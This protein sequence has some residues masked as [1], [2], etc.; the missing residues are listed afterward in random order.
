L[1][2]AILL[3]SGGIDSATLL[4]KVREEYEVHA[5]TIRYGR[6]NRMEVKSSRA[7]ARL[8]GATEHII[9]SMGNM[10]E[11]EA[12]EPGASARL[13]VPSCYIPA[14]NAVIFGIAA[15]F[16]ELRGA[17]VILTGQ[18][19]DDDFPDSRQGFLDAYS[20]I[21]AMSK[22]PKLE[23]KTRLVA[24]LI[25]MRKVE[26]FRM[27]KELGVPLEMTWSCHSDGEVPCGACDGCRSVAELVEEVP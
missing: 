24:P 17:S 3:L 25:G 4:W 9:F 21:I 10:L 13:G 14:R 12:H 26:V 15:H 6:A 16:A 27:A 8:A 22:P 18:N 1:K 2:K 23:M 20:Q 11:L 7:L 19:R 5:L